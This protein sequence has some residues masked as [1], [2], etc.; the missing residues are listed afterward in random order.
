MHTSDP[1]PRLPTTGAGAHSLLYAALESLGDDLPKLLV[2]G[3]ETLRQRIEAR[4]TPSLVV[5]GLPSPSDDDT[6]GRR[7]KDELERVML[8]LSFIAHAYVW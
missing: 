4:L 1:L 6:G 7:I 8:L 3:N 5:I 2:C